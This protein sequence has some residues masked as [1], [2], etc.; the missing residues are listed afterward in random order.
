MIRQRRA[1][2]NIHFSFIRKIIFNTLISV[3][4]S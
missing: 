2:D 4:K 1:M 3:E